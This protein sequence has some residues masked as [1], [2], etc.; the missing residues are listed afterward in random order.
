MLY[1]RFEPP[2]AGDAP[3]D[4]SQNGTEIKRHLDFQDPRL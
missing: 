2:L 3:P 1:E 4:L